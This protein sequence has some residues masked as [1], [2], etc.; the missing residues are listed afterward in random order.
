MIGIG[1]PKSHSKI[2]RPIRDF[3]VSDQQRSRRDCS[4][5]HSVSS[6]ALGAATAL[7][8]TGG[9]RPDRVSSKE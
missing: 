4:P 1:T 3:L 7:P 8:G 5:E 2:P 6:Q 9:N